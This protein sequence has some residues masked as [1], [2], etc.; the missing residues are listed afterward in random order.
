MPS[1]MTLAH[2]SSNPKVLAVVH[3]WSEMPV[4]VRN[5][6]LVDDICRDCDMAPADFV[7]EIA[8][9]AY[10]QSMDL[11]RLMSSFGQPKAVE[12]M[13]QQAQTPEGIADRRM[14]FQATG[15]LPSPQG[16]TFNV[17]ADA[18]VQSQTVII[19]SGNLLSFEER[20][21]R[22]AKAAYTPLPDEDDDVRS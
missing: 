7:A 1:M 21:V 13:C 10:R 12:A 19:P 2:N 22:A 5:K 8:R 20:V 14:L 9:E 16:A 3:R 18:R 6:A 15:L 11:S 17:S 4:G